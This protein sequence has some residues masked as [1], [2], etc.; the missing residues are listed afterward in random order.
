M[1]F[2]D[3]GYCFAT[4]EHVANI[5]TAFQEIVRVTKPGG[6]IYCLSAP[7]WYASK[8]HHMAIFFDYPWI[9]LRHDKQGVLQFAEESGLKHDTVPM[10][11]LVDYMFSDTYFNK[12]HARRYVEICESLPSVIIL[13][14]D[15]QFDPITDGSRDILVELINKGHDRDDLLASV[16]TFI[17]KKL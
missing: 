8:G 16:H 10:P 4:L 15:L 11:A 14:N 2:T 1:F 7:L 17:A 12:Q 13:Q 6:F 9:H 5:D 3:L